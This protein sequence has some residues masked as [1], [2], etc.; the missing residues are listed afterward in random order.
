MP[1]P[2]LTAR[3]DTWRLTDCLVSPAGFNDRGSDAF[4]EADGELG[5][6]QRVPDDGPG[7]PAGT[8]WGPAGAG[9]LLP[10]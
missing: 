9:L 4:D 2:H 1:G 7:P 3:R 6:Q 8:G 5:G 10:A